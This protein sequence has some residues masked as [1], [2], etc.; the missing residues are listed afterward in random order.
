MHKL[1]SYQSFPL[2]AMLAQVLVGVAHSKWQWR[3]KE[4]E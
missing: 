3:S 2:V 4:A 1:T